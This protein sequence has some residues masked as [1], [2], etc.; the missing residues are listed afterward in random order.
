MGIGT[1]VGRV[2]HHPAL[3]MSLALVAVERLVLGGAG[4]LNATAPP[5]G[6][7]TLHL[8][9]LIDLPGSVAGAVVGPW[10]RDDGLWYQWI[11]TG[12][13][14][15]HPAQVAFF[16][17]YPGIVHVVGVVFGGSF[18]AA[19]LLVSTSALIAGLVLLHNLVAGDLGAAAARRTVL[20]AA[21]APFAFFYLAPFTESLF[22]L[23]SV[24]A[25][26]A[27]RRRRFLLAGGI[28]ALAAACRL[29][30]VVLILPLAWEAIVDAR[31]RRP[32][33][34]HLA[35][36]LPVVALG[37]V[38]LFLSAQGSPGGY[39]GAERA[40]WGNHVAAPWT[41]LSE[42]LHAIG[43]GHHPAEAANLV[44]AVVFVAAL[45]WMWK[46]LPHSYTL[47][48]AGM[49]GPL[50]FQVHGFSPLMSTGRYTL[51]IFPLFALLALL[52]PSARGGRI[53]VT[54]SAA[55]MLAFF[56]G[57]TRYHIIG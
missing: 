44:A 50:W 43:T 8:N 3:R 46:R 18:G 41:V 52:T 9:R 4:C 29:Q 49:A 45:P 16:P 21:C 15:A 11:A 1:I 39:L 7:G 55:L 38:L 28:A 19:A 32:R 42:S 51:V 17:L 25:I 53:V 33:W 36:L 24:G 34:V 31:E 14:G 22:L 47:Y 48:A 40:Y 10:Q 23:L 27:A 35:A 26:L 56:L 2:W 12:G 54:I 37:A 5:A 57:F 30:G 13:Y 6:S 20:Y